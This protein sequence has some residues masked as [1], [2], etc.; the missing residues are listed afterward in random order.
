MVFRCT[1]RPQVARTTVLQG[2]PRSLIAATGLDW[3]PS[4][5]SWRRGELS[6]A[7]SG[8]TD[9]HA[10]RAVQWKS[11]FLLVTV[12]LMSTLIT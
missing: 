3:I 11:I 1:R 9:H 5:T 6:A 2:L 7:G 4:A 12:G 10:R 8:S